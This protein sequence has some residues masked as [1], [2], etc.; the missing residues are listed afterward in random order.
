MYAEGMHGLGDTI[1]QRPFIKWFSKHYDR[2]WLR[3][4]WPQLYQD[5]PN[6]DY[7]YCG[8]G[9]RAQAKNLQLID[10]KIPY[11]LRS[12]AEGQ[13]THQAVF[14][15]HFAEL[16]RF[17]I[18]ETFRRET[19]LMNVK[20]DFDLP[21]FYKPKGITDQPYLVIRPATI[22]MEWKNPARN[23]DPAMLAKAVDL[24]KDKY[25]I[26][27]VADVQRDEEEFEGEPPFAHTKIHKGELN[28]MDLMGL[29]RHS[30][31]CVGGV[32]WIVPAAH[33]YK[34]PLLCILGG[35]G[36]HNHPNKISDP[37]QD[38]SQTVWAFPDN[39]CMCK[40]FEHPCQKYIHRI[41][42]Y[43]NEFLEILARHRKPGV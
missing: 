34:V 4:P 16:E 38:L 14:A 21:P 24:L 33:A 28:V 25:H 7:V 2:V 19:G 37:D 30:A 6:V 43:V 29:V 35:M 32:G 27:S 23:P 18:I 17:S 42:E 26:I 12:V 5:L 39:F 36:G 20:L 1:F 41:P 8:S 10:R 3:T 22:R 15:Y 13:R 31:G 40:S 11:I 9:L